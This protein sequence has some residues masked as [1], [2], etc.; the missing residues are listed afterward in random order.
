MKKYYDILINGIPEGL[1]V[2]RIVRGKA[3]T[4]AELDDGSFGIAMHTAGRS[5]KRLFP[6]LVGMEA[7][8]AAQAVMSWNMEE[9]SEGMAVINAYYNSVSRMDSLG[10]LDDYNR[11][12]TAGMETEGKKI[13]LIGHLKLHPDALRGAKEVYIIEREPREGD[14]PDSACEYIL[15][16]CDIVI[17]T[18]SA[19]VNKTMP[20]LL[21]LS[22]AAQTI[23][24]GPTV[25]L[26]PELKS[27]GISR[28]S[29]LVVTDIAGITGWMTE[30][31][32]SPYP[33]GET[34]TI[35]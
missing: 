18:G 14:Y 33:F 28:L 30:V 1:K 5:I 7:A 12:V 17:I 11:C 29:G 23:V 16:E 8:A 9:A 26:C 34:F 2:R 22:E 24:V 10:C 13:A 21:E 27:C 25:P 32:G 15:P 19:A 6:S 4:G 31:K 20:R 35:Y 3:W